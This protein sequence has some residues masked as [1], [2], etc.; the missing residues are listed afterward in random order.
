MMLRMLLEP[1]ATF[2]VLLDD[3]L[4]LGDTQWGRRRV[5]PITGGSFEGSRLRGEVVP[6]GSDWQVLH[7]DGMITVDTRYLLRTHDG[8][9]ITLATNGV[10]HGPPEVVRRINAGEHVD[11]ASYYFRLFCRFET[12]DPRYQWLTRTLVVASAAREANAVRYQAYT[13]T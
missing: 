13:L 5:V 3:I 6:G 8:V 10:R 1:L 4:D 7:S 9:L 11:P 2:H 12:G